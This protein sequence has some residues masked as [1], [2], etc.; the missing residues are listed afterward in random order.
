MKDNRIKEPIRVYSR[1]QYQKPIIKKKRPH[2]ILAIIFIILACVVVG[3][4]IGLSIAYSNSSPTDL[5][6]IYQY[7]IDMGTWFGT[8]VAG[9]ITWVQSDGFT[10]SF[11][12]IQSIVVTV[13]GLL[14][15]L[16][17]IKTLK[18]K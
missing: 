13:G 15:I 14:T 17:A 18:K 8:L 16:V 9:I 11:P 7:F 12:M 2:K 5:K 6:T 1:P 10:K 3:V 4:S